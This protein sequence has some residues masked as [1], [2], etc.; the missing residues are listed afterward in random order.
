MFIT[1]IK[2]I[3][4]IKPECLSV[5]INA[6]S[7]KVI[8]SIDSLSKVMFMSRKFMEILDLLRSATQQS[9]YLTGRRV[10]HAGILQNLICFNVG[11]SPFT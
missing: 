7:I 11:S 5:L 9:I 3:N 6:L 4:L 1:Y 8:K 10:V 2:I